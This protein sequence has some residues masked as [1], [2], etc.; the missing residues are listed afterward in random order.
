M[1]RVASLRL[2]L[3]SSSTS[4]NKRVNQIETF[5]YRVSLSEDVSR[6]YY[7]HV[8]NYINIP[9]KCEIH[10]FVV[11]FFSIGDTEQSLTERLY[12][13]YLP[14]HKTE[15]KKQKSTKIMY[16]RNIESLYLEG[17]SIESGSRRK[18]EEE[19]KKRKGEISTFIFRIFFHG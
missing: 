3:A 18:I 14:F 2:C 8:H 19:G 15:T 6:I 5:P 7:R 13:K 9:N 11:L 16:T 12:S 4:L 10:S 17:R 1:S